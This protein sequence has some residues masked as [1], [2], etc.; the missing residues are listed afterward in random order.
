MRGFKVALATV[1]AGAMLGATA[2][3]YDPATNADSTEETTTTPALLDVSQAD[4]AEQQAAH[5]REDARNIVK[6]SRHFQEQDDVSDETKAIAAEAESIFQA[7]IDGLDEVK[8]KGSSMLTDSEVE[9]IESDSGSH[10]DMAYLTMLETHVPR[11]LDA[12]NG[13]QEAGSEPVRNVARETF[14]KLEALNNK[15]QNRLSY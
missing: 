1:A 2:C 8:D 11:L 10:L 5:L 9:R 15:V 3:S 7:Q 4:Y 12:W 13:M 14:P 6:L